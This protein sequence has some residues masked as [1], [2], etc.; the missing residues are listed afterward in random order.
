MD[1]D[2]DLRQVPTQ[3]TILLGSQTVCQSEG[4]CF[5]QALLRR[6]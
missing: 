5:L 2:D 1:E 4:V 6:A 3:Q